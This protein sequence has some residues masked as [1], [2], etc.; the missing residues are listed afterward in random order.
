[1][2][3]YNFFLISVIVLFFYF[4]S[5]FLVKSQKITQIQHRRFWNI[6]LLTTF[7]VSCFLGLFLAFSVDQQLSLKFYLPLIWYHVEFGI[8]MA[9]VAIFHTFWHLPYFKS[10]FQKK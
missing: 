10:I 4:L 6:I 2:T 5:F 3:N 8:V 9:I 1:M 7:L